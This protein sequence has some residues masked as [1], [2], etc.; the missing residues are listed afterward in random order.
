M[1]ATGKYKIFYLFL[2]VFAF[3]IY[4]S[5]PTDLTASEKWAGVDE[6]VIEKFAKEF[7]IEPKEPLINTDQGDL[8]LFVF[9]LAGV[10]GGFI[11]GYYWRE[12]I[13]YKDRKA[14]KVLVGSKKT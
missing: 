1:K 7:G 4:F 8:L 6:S 3:S 12:L 5:L 13:D 2:I 9:L 11:A 10:V 14:E